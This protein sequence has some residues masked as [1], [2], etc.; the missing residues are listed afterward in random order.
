MNRF[1]LAAVCVAFSASALTSDEKPLDARINDVCSVLRAET[2]YDYAGLFGPGFVQQVPESQFKQITGGLVRQYGDCQNASVTRRKA[3]E[4]AQI[5]TQHAGGKT[6]NFNIQV[7]T[8]SGQIVGLLFTGEAVDASA[9]DSD[10]K[11]LGHFEQVPGQV[12]VLVSDGARALISMHPDVLHATGSMFKMWVLGALADAI[13]A[14]EFSWDQTIEVREEL[15]TL[16]SP[17][18]SKHPK[19]EPMT[20]QAMAEAMISV[21]DNGA[22]DH[23]IDLLGRTRIEEYIARHGL[24]R[25]NNT[26]FLYTRELFKVRAKFSEDDY[27]RYKQGDR[28][29]R[30]AML[31]A[32]PDRTTM[33]LVVDLSLWKKPHHIEDVEWYATPVDVCKTVLH[34]YA[35]DNP[36]V[37]RAMSINTPM[38][39]GIDRPEFVGYK[40]GSEPGVLEMAYVVKLADQAPLC[41]YAGVNDVDNPV[42]ESAFVAHVRGLLRHVIEDRRTVD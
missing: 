7:D 11:V 16:S 20:V 24:S 4:A 14:G 6:L 39:Q 32:L 9:Y 38:P 41:V 13:N 12:S 30:L 26:P 36:Q 19:G 17:T 25:G 10:E 29:T 5:Q 27:T 37:N 31:E 35:L 23:L 21:S 22:T 18:L 28:A 8:G 2:E 33:Q 1:T 15:I 42:D 3:D 40:G 34:L